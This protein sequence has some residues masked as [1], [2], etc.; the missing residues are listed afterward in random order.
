V[1]DVRLAAGNELSA[2]ELVADAVGHGK[3]TDGCTYNL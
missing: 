2:D 1:S 3:R